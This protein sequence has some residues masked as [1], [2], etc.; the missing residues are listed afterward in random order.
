MNLRRL[1]GIVAILNVVGCAVLAVYA[2]RERRLASAESHAFA[3]QLAPLD[4]D[5]TRLREELKQLR[6]AVDKANAERLRLTASA[7]AA[8]ASRASDRP[9]PGTDANAVTAR[10][11]ALAARRAEAVDKLRTM[12]EYVSYMV[13]NA[14]R[15]VMREYGDAIDALHLPADKAEKLKQLLTDR[16]LAQTDAKLVAEGKGE[17]ENGPAALEL[18]R[19][20]ESE[21]Q[22]KTLELLGEKGADAFRE[23]VAFFNVRR[24]FLNDCNIVLAERGIP[25][26]TDD[27]LFRCF[28]GNGTAQRASNPAVN[29]EEWAKYLRPHMENSLTPAQFE[30]F[31]DHTYAWIRQVVLRRQVTQQMRRG[32]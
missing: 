23:Q 15:N 9:T 4:A 30:V 17:G 29:R 26:L 7:K 19:Q 20:I 14:R 32:G 16:E 5:R 25:Q 3:A 28:R 6:E 1:L 11:E 21:T 24:A 27:Q 12:P 31:V 13:R 8:S 18:L 10:R 22:A 2:S